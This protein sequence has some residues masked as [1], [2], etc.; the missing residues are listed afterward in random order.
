MV[1]WQALLLDEVIEA[2]QVSSE[3]LV[4]STGCRYA[5]NIG[6]RRAVSSGRL[7]RDPSQPAVFSHKRQTWVG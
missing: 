4:S 6:Y 1:A 5:R 3:Y 2:M 7:V